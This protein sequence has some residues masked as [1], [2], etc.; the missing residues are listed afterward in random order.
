[1]KKMF[2]FNNASHWRQLIQWLFLGWCLFLGVQ[3]GLFVRHFE[4]KGAFGYFP[5][6]PGVEAFLPIGSLVSLKTWL[7]TGYFDVVHHPGEHSQRSQQ[8]YHRQRAHFDDQ[9]PASNTDPDHQKQYS[10]EQ[11][12]TMPAEDQQS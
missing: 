9:P 10:N 6:P 2:K 12:P 1:M 7:L 8:R 11:K 4:S 5:R 3:F